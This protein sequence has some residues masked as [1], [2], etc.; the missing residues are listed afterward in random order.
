MTLKSYIFFLLVMV[1]SNV[2]A[3][4]K[5]GIPLNTAEKDQIKAFLKTLTDNEFIKNTLYSE[6]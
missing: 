6:S 4:L 3:Q 1:A 2:D 5:N